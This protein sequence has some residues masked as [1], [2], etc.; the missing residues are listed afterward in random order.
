MKSLLPFQST[1]LPTNRKFGF[2]IASV[3]LALAIYAYWKIWVEFAIVALSLCAVFSALALAAPNLLLPLN[4]LWHSFGLLIGMVV[5]PIVL[6]A[7]FFLLIS[8]IS[9]I[10]RLF[11]RD[12]LKMKKRSVDSYWVC[13]SPQEPSP[14][15]FKNQY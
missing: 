7:I 10:T 9:L 15:S 4:K 1:L 11:G 13:R 12:E 3:F 8:P 6:G 5:S 14:D 2:F